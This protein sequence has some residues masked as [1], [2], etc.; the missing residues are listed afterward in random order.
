MVDKKIKWGEF[1]ERF[2]SCSNDC[3]QKAEI[4]NLQIGRSESFK[5]RDEVFPDNMSVALGDDF[6]DARRKAI[7]HPEAYFQDGSLKY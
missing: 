4:E 3:S 7:R 2:G 5:L 1:E 6:R